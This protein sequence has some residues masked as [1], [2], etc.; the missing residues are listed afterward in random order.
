[1]VGEVTAAQRAAAARAD[2]E[3]L[4]SQSTQIDEDVQEE[5]EEEEEET[6]AFDD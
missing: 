1:M 5:E 2:G 4:D 3:V 6:Q